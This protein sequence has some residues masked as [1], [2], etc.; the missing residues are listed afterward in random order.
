MRKLSCMRE[1]WIRG[2]LSVSV[3]GIAAGLLLA[4]FAG[5]GRVAMP[6]GALVAL[7]CTIGLLIVII[8][9][10]LLEL[11]AVRHD[12]ELVDDAAV[13]TLTFAPPALGP[14]TRPSNLRRVK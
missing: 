11:A 7:V 5:S 3:A 6:A 2:G 13:S 14:I 1:T 9:V 10:L 8:G 4:A 12:G